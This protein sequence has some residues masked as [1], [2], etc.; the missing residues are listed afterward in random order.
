MYL[1]FFI[2]TELGY[3][4]WAFLRRKKKLNCVYQKSDK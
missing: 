3:K 1:Y 4:F 2:K